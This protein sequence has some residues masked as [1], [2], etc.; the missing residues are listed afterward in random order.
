M[1]STRRPATSLRRAPV[2]MNTNRMARSRRSAKLEPLHVASNAL[3]CASSSTGTGGTGTL[4]GRMFRMGLLSVTSPSS[5]HQES[6]LPA[7]PARR[8]RGSP[9]SNTSAARPRPAG[10]TEPRSSS[11]SAT[12]KPAGCR[13]QSPPS[14]ASTWRASS[15]TSARRGPRRRSRRGIRRSANSRPCWWIPRHRR[16]SFPD[17]HTVSSR[18][19]FRQVRAAPG[20]ASGRPEPGDTSP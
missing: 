2:S 15:S 6:P 18:G 14:G 17:P 4:G 11:F 19:H 12:S 7:S 16:I 13:R 1:S 9:A 5:T 3:S 20:R 8:G 10:P